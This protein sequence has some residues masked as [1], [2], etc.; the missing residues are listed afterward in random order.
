VELEPDYFIQPD[1]PDKPW[2]IGKSE[3]HWFPDEEKEAFQKALQS[4]PLNP[5]YVEFGTFLGAGSTKAAL[6]ARSDIQ[7]LCFDDFTITGELIQAVA[8]KADRPGALPDNFQGSDFAAGIGTALQ[9]CQNNLWDYRGRVRLF[10]Q[11]ISHVT[12]DRL[13]N[14]GVMPDCVLIDDHHEKEPF[15]KRLFRCRYRWPQAVIICDDYCKAWPGVMEGVSEAF[16]RGWYHDSEATMLG[17]RM[18]A[19]KR[20]K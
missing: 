14:S 6:E 19:F 17:K 12:V 7:V 5:V 18:I 8:D 1:W 2:P 16:K 4:L 15:I 13:A 20:K 3:C 9:H 10:E 11:G